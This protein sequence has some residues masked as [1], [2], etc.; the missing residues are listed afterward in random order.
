MSN[1]KLTPLRVSLALSLAALAFT[2][3]ASAL[4]G[5]PPPTTGVV[6]HRWLFDEESGATAYDEAALADGTLG[7]SA[8]RSAGVF[9]GAV[10]ISPTGNYD[11]NGYVDFGNEVG[12]FGDAD[13]TLTHWYRTSFST[14]GAHGD[15]L[16]NRTAGSQ[17]NYFGARLVGDGTIVVEL[18]QDSWGSNYQAIAASN[19]GVNDGQW[20]HL[21]YVRSGVTLSLYIDGALAAQGNAGSGQPIF[22]NGSS[23]FRIGRRL[24]LGYGNFHTIPASYDD[25]RLFDRALS[26]TE[27]AD[28]VDGAL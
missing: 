26:D 2:S 23:S 14:L 25:L 8:T 6:E 7:S 18:A 28:V 3:T 27:V 9:L 12:A 22:V 24:P 11:G 19:S 15:I 5:E 17:G 4:I 10:T 1:R 21:A 13:F 16:G 20:H